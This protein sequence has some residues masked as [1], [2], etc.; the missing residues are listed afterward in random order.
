MAAPPPKQSKELATAFRDDL[1]YQAR[2]DL[3]GVAPVICNLDAQTDAGGTTPAATGRG[4]VQSCRSESGLRHLQEHGAPSRCSRRE[5]SPVESLT[6]RLARHRF[7]W[8]T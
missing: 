1:L 8:R 6:R 2:R 3:R 4:E 5:R 7:L